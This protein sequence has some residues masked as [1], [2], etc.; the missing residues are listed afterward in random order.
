MEINPCYTM[1]RCQDCDICNKHVKLAQ[2]D[3]M[4]CAVCERKRFGENYPTYKSQ[5]RRSKRE[6]KPTKLYKEFETEPSPVTRVNKDNSHSQEAATVIS[7]QDM[8]GRHK[9]ESNKKPRSGK[10]QS[11]NDG[12]SNSSDS[13]V[14]SSTLNE[15]LVCE[16]LS[17]PTLECSRCQGCYCPKCLQL[18]DSSFKLMKSIPGSVWLCNTCVAPGIK[19][20]RQDKEIEERCAEYLANMTSRIECLE[21]TM[22]SKPSKTEVQEMIR[23]Q[24]KDN[25]QKSVKEVEDRDRRRL[26]L[27]IQ[28]QPES[29]QEN[30]E[31]RQAKDIQFF[32]NI[33]NTHLGIGITITKATR[34]GK[35]DP[36]R[37]RPRPLK[38]TVQDEQEKRN[39]LRK[40]S[41]LKDIED[42]EV[43]KNLFVYPDLT[44]AQQREE[45]ELREELKKTRR[46]EKDSSIE[47]IIRKGQI[48]SRKRIIRKP[49]PTQEDE[50]EETE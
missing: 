42:D 31:D 44:P 18:P 24:L 38:I 27:I 12:N 25:T 35:K 39:I 45:K 48:I 19:C 7:N 3:L 33:C 29:E 46:Q 43:A 22:S 9:Q 4:L 6:L 11:I 20:M 37:T 34:L 8:S 16:E 49:R 14:G 36:Q 30:P 28:N 13:Q 23:V 26:N 21:S 32:N 5:V 1:N 15:C 47:W 10:G 40:A 2:G 17:D 41:E 50:E